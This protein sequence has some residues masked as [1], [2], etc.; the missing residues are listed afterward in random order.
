MSVLWSTTGQQ[1]KQQML[2]CGWLLEMVNPEYSV[3]EYSDFYKSGIF[4]NW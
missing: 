2:I 1:W 3:I 4:G